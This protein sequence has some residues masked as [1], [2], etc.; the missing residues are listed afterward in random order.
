ML[1]LNA[2]IVYFTKSSASLA[3]AFTSLAL[4][5]RVHITHIIQHSTTLP[6]LD[7]QLEHRAA[8]QP[9]QT[10]PAQAQKR[11]TQITQY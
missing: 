10:K 5:Y 11:N 9:N 6:Y 7:S 4:S 1:L 2:F 8:K 3:A